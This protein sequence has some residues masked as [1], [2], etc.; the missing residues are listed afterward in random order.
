MLEDA[1]VPV[2]AL[3]RRVNKVLAHRG[4]ILLVQALLRLKLSFTMGKAAS[5]ILRKVLA[6]LTFE[7]VLT[8]LSL[9]FVLP[10]SFTLNSRSSIDWDS[11]MLMLMMVAADRSLLS[12]EGSWLLGC[13]LV[14]LQLHSLLLLRVMRSSGTSIGGVGID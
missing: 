3:F 4:Q 8:Q 12:A 2:R 5:L 1:P 9:N 6:G 14:R 7:P 10:L 13:T 11:L